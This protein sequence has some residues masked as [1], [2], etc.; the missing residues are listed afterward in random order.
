MRIKRALDN[1]HLRIFSNVQIELN[2]FRG[3]IRRERIKDRAIFFNFN[4][5]DP[6]VVILHLRDEILMIIS[7]LSIQLITWWLTK[8]DDTTNDL[9]IAQ[10]FYTS[11][12]PHKSLMICNKAVIGRLP[13]Q[14][15]TREKKII[16]INLKTM[17]RNF[18][19][20]FVEWTVWAKGE[21]KNHDSLITFFFFIIHL[22]SSGVRLSC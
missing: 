22:L 14:F 10:D 12:K 16:I 5:V 1:K 7:L 2:N 9:N 18:P 11:E 4:H 15:A 19:S 13:I 6:A 20:L 21:K 17:E 3:Q 8:S